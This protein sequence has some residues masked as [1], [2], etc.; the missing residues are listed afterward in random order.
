V[1]TPIRMNRRPARRGVVLLIV[2]VAI[3][4]IAAALVEVSR[5]SS[6]SQI[7]SLRAR[8]ALQ[9]RWGMISCER[10]VLPAAAGLLARSDES[11]KQALPATAGLRRP[12]MPAVLTDR[13]LLGGQSFDLILADEDAKADLN[14]IYDIGGRNGCEKVLGDTLA[15]SEMRAVRLRPRRRSFDVRTAADS[16]GQPSQL[17]GPNAGEISVSPSADS[18]PPAFATWGEVFDFNRVNDLSGDL[19]HI[20]AATREVTL[21]GSGRLNVWRASDDAIVAVCREVVQ[22]GLA[23]RIQQRI[24]ST[25]LSQIDLV[26]RQ[27]VSNEQ[28]RRRLADLLADDSRCSSLWIEG[29]DGVSRVQRLSIRRP[30]KTGWIR[31][32]VFEFP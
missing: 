17:G 1:R 6:Q 19:R 32:T 29:D 26:L 7:A 18:L 11:T 3:V 23:K 16:R 21:W 25:S 4:L 27:T 8:D 28:D 31:T 10:V 12:R 22:D 5:A 20:A 24:R 30:E 15:L 2:L 14:V 13:V 9:Q